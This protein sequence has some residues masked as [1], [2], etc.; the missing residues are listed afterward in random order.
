MHAPEENM[1]PSLGKIYYRAREGEEPKVGNIVS[2]VEISYNGSTYNSPIDWITKVFENSGKQI[3]YVTFPKPQP[4]E[5]PD[6]PR[7]FY[8][9]SSTKKMRNFGSYR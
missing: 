4:Q 7:A 2:S 8:I 3:R 9:P 1:A 6:T 5:Q